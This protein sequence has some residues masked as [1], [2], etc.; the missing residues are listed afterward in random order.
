MTA[1]YPRA[2]LVSEALYVVTKVV[3]VYGLA[4]KWVTSWASGAQ[5][6]FLATSE[7]REVSTSVTFLIRPACFV[8]FTEI[9]NLDYFAGGD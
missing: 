8:L 1:E 4:G 2:D 9:F 6:E 7:V 3:G 5:S